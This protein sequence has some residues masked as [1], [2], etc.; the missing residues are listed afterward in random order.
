[1]PLFMDVHSNAQGFTIDQ[2][3]AAHELDLEAQ[4]RY[5]TRYLTYWFNRDA[6]KIFC[7][8]DAPSSQA[9]VSSTSVSAR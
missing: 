3:V 6:G 7:L 5:D 4:A 2:V 1:M 9:A 8:V